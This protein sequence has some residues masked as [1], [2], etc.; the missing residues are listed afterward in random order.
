MTVTRTAATNVRVSW[1]APSSG[2][3]LGGYEVFY[4]MESSVF[5]S[6]TDSASTTQLTLN[7][8]M[9]EQAYSIFV[10][11]FGQEGAPVLPSGHSNTAMITL[12][13]FISYNIGNLFNFEIHCQQVKKCFITK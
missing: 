13:Q 5:S 12:G 2:P 7:G 8:L 4:Q 10:V 1:T 6:S 9:V 3:D 11:A